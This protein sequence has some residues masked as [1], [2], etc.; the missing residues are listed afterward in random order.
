VAYL[1]I[2]FYKQLPSKAGDGF[3]VIFLG[4]AAPFFF[5]A[6]TPLGHPSE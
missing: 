6:I 3:N 1:F 2:C 5:T 4:V